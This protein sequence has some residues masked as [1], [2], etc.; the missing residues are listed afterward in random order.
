MMKAFGYMLFLLGLMGL[1][2]S[3][4]DCDGHCM[5]RANDLYTMMILIVISLVSIIL[6]GCM[7]YLDHKYNSR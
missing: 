6:G 7:I 2:G 3:A 4:G 1:A 5:E